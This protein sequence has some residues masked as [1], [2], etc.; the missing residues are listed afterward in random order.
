MPV[1]GPLV[2]EE[3][4]AA[5]CVHADEWA[6]SAHGCR[7][8]IP[9]NRCSVDW[10]GASART[11][12]RLPGVRAAAAPAAAASGSPLSLQARPL[13]PSEAERKLIAAKKQLRTARAEARHYKE[14]LEVRGLVWVE[15]TA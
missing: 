9:L 3:G 5:A 12:P 6:S 1:R 2:H 7:P 10:A 14:N 13:E 8:Q 15:G 4:Q 11:G